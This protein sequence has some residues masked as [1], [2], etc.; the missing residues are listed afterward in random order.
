M[1][2]SEYC[3][4]QEDT[5]VGDIAQYTPKLGSKKLL[6]E[7]CGKK[8]K[9]SAVGAVGRTDANSALEHV[10]PELRARFKKLLKDVG[11]KTVMRY[12]LADTT[13]GQ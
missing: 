2:F 13:K 6:C 10:T 5:S 1:K 8:L 11:G 12:L 7:E 4:I 9:E 3:D